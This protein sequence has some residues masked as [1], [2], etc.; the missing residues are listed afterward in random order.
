MNKFKAIIPT[1]DMPEEEWLAYRANG[2]GG[3]D[4][5]TVCG[6]N[7]YKSAYAL[8]A[9]RTNLI[10]RENVGNEA[11]DWGH[12]LERVI[13][14]KYAHDHKQAVVAWPV[15][16]VSEKNDFMFANI[17]FWIVEP[18]PDFPVG[19]VTDWKNNIE[20]AGVKAILEVKT[21]GIASPG[22]VHQWS[23]N[24]IPQSYVLQTVH[25]GIVTG[26]HEII[27]AALLPPTGLQVRHLAWDEELAENL[28]IIEQQFWDLVQTNT[29]PE[30]D[31]SDATEA[32]QAA[33]YPRHEAGKGLEGGMELKS[34]W[35]EFSAAKVAAEEADKVRKGLRA[36]II[37]VVGNAEY[38]TVDGNVILTYKAGKEVESLDTDRLR[39]EAPEIFEQFKK[40]RPSSRTLRGV[41]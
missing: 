17:D 40:F 9:E 15:I 30:V 38:A 12:R 16:L 37:E 6:V 1:W 28:V 23:N 7:K 20:P 33:R 41:K 3:S 31:G 36:K 4:A 32:A 26:V 11:T 35:E 22:T 13:A 29:A 10:E 25:Y 34:L 27:F 8:W 18:T 21:S 2:L 19:V 14:E 39:R 24:S 5:G